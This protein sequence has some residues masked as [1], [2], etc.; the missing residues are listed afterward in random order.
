MGVSTIAEPVA[1]CYS[2]LGVSHN[3]AE[4][5][6]TGLKFLW[7][8][9]NFEHLSI[10]AIEHEVMCAARA[11]I[12]HIIGG[13]LM[14]DGNNNKVHLMYLPLFADLQNVRSYSW[15]SA[16]LTMLY[17]ELCQ[18][19][20]PDAV[21]IDGCLILLQ[22]WALYQISFLASVRHQ[23]Y[24]LPLVNRWSFYPGIGR[25]YI[26]SIYRLMIEQYVGEGMVEWY[27]R[28]RVLRQFGCIQYI[29]VPPMQLGK[30]HRINNR[31]KQG[32]N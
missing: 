8:K 6:F 3:N 23:A 7:L 9:A 13:V 19:T 27:H 20:K 11:Y 21:D 17:R 29:P 12:M 5:N 25:S 26:V 32:N 1:L 31:G 22:S 2:L 16:V 24:V 18:A 14:P 10:N 28:D 30:I 15:G 4:S